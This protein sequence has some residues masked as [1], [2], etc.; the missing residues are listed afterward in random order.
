[1]IYVP[2]M[3]HEKHIVVP[4]WNVIE[5]RNVIE[6]TPVTTRRKSLFY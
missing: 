4:I 1:M 6:T 5:T 3:I 2:D